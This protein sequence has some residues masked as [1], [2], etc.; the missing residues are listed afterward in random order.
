MNDR[1]R[2]F[3]GLICRLILITAVVLLVYNQ[4][5][6]TIQR[7]SKTYKIGI[8]GFKKT[9]D[10]FVVKNFT[11]LVSNLTLCATKCDMIL[12]HGKI[13]YYV[14]IGVSVSLGFSCLLIIGGM[15][16]DM[17]MRYILLPITILGLVAIAVM[18]GLFEGVSFRS[19]S[20]LKDE[21]H[22][23]ANIFGLYG[24]CAFYFFL[25]IVG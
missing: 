17:N 13:F 5:M 24:C 16:A 1:I 3:F 23:G 12:Y 14:A 6:I 20:E 9:N 8:R 15:I 10:L 4:N 7:N 19:L 25:L 21:V 22:R 18:I 11:P 2:H